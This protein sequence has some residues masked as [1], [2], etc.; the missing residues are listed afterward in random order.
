MKKQTLRLFW[1]YAVRYKGRMA[2]AFIMP[3][4]AVLLTGFISPLILSEFINQLQLG[5]VTLENTGNLVIAYAICQ[6]LGE[7]VIWR[8][9]LWAGWKSEVRAERDLYTD[10]FGALSRQTSSFHADRFSGS[11][12]SQANKLVGAFERFWDMIIWQLIPMITT[13]L[14]ASIILGTFFWQYAV[15]ILVISVLFATTVYI[16][17]R[18][19]A[20]R[21]TIE[22]QKYN[23]M[24]GLLSDMIGNILAVKAYANEKT[25]YKSARKLSKSWVNA[26]LS[27]MRGVIGST[28]AYSSILVL[29]TTGALLMAVLVSER[30]FVPIGTIYLMLTYTLNVGRQLWEMNSI[31]RNYNRI[32][33]DAHDMVEILGEP[34]IVHDESCH[35]LV[36][37]KGHIVFDDVSFSHQSGSQDLLFD[38]FPLSISPGERV[39]LVGR[40]GSGKTTLTN[41]LLR[42]MDVDGGAV[43]IDGQNIRQVTQESLRRS[44]AYVPQEPMLFH[45]SLSEN[46]AYGKPDAS[47]E[48]IV[49][50]AK[51]ANA[52]DFI[53]QLDKGYDTLVGERGVK[54]SGGQRQRIAIA[55]AILKDAPILILDEA[56][57]ALDSESEKLIQASLTSLMKGRTSIVIAHRLSTISKLDRIVVLDEGHIVE[58]GT[59]ASLLAHR[60]TYAKLWQHQSGGF[61]DVD[62]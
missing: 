8:I 23:R 62:E 37:D 26:S 45:R 24:S 49:E 13:I 60:G 2:V 54:L 11:M 18:F 38:H 32:M 28:T 22:A 5:T 48:E 14:A 57:S 55:R 31:M 16:S 27:T 30:S 33:G 56:T 43:V 17:S 53:L 61:I 58:D 34:V 12:V 19:L 20:K 3:V 35:N 25:E 47:H 1:R 40:S 42:F 46:I 21:N 59:H 44:I 39:G 9:A 10:I 36:V 51:K 4:C 41:L 50:A 29:L 15:L 52:H 7:V 6:F